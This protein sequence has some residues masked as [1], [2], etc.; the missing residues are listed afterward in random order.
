MMSHVEDDG[1]GDLHADEHHVVLDIRY[2]PGNNKSVNE[3][4]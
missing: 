2:T 4:Q 1:D 3:R